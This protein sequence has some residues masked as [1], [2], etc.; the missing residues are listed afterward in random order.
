[1]I[2]ASKRGSCFSGGGVTV[3]C[4]GSAGPVAVQILVHVY[5]SALSSLRTSR[6]IDA[7]DTTVTSPHADIMLVAR[8]PEGVWAALCLC[9]S[10]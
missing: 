2:V 6:D 7:V 3:A 10:V 5:P 1:M 9:V 4:C 8:L